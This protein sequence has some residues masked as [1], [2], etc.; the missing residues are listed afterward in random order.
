MDGHAGGF[1]LTLRETNRRV[2]VQHATPLA[3][4]TIATS[5]SAKIRDEL[6]LEHLRIPGF[7]HFLG[8]PPPEQ[9]FK[10]Y[11]DLD[12]FSNGS[13]QQLL[14]VLM[15]RLARR[16][17]APA[18]ANLDGKASENPNLPSGYTY[19]L[20]LTAHDLVYTSVPISIIEH[21]TTGALNVRRRGLRL[22]TIY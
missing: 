12:P 16:M 11:D 13:S 20:Q 19:L 8:E 6:E 18:P 4:A 21:L 17:S 3:D 7:R 10:I 9:R 22:D 15:E 5:K 1:P 14:R 2:V